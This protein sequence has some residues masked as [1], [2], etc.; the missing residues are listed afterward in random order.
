MLKMVLGILFY[1]VNLLFWFDGVVKCWWMVIFND[2]AFDSLVEKIQFSSWEDWQFLEGMVFIKYFELFKVCFNGQV[3]L[4]E[5]CF[6][7]LGMDGKSYGLIYKWNDEGM[8]VF[9]FKADVL[10]IFMFYEG[11]MFVV[12]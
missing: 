8:D 4:L 1:Q 12:E 10:K 11:G 3:V 2:G 5:I 9:F 6:F 7:V